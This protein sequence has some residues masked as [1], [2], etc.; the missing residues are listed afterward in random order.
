M[1]DACDTT[2]H[3]RTDFPRGS[4]SSSREKI[5][6]VAE[7]LFARSGYS[8][9]GLREVA[10]LAG[11]GKSSLFHHFPSKSELHLAVLLRVFERIDAVVAP[12]EGA[13]GSATE[14]LDRMLEALV[15][16]LVEQPTTARL[17]LRGLLEED[18]LDV[19]S[20]SHAASQQALD[21]LLLRLHRAIREGVTTGE[22]RP[23]H[24]GHLLQTLI[25]ATVYHYASGEFGEEL[26]GGP[27]FSSAAVR[28]RK[29]EIRE[30]VHGGI[31]LRGPT[32]PGERT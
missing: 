30:L 6:D 16:A 13:S 25:G 31:V 10:S 24:P 19:A 27:L 11:L 23:V 15:D 7:A 21:R 32:K 18:E 8:G 29:Q 4:E 20:P 22:F 14:R 9:V 5:L 26:I 3:P 12:H 28:A 2:R 17:L 1:S